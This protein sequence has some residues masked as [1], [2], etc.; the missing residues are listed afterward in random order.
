MTVATDD[1]MGPA[2]GVMGQCLSEVVE[3]CDCDSGPHGYMQAKGTPVSFLVGKSPTDH[4]A[5]PQWAKNTHE[6]LPPR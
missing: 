4:F 1:M 5:S 2:L 6:D 3:E